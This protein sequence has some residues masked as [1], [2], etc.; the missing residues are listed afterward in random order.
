MALEELRNGREI[1]RISV[2]VP[3]NGDVEVSSLSSL[4]DHRFNNGAGADGRLL[5]AMAP[6]KP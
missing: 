3:N 2:E 1:R 6:G 4:L 5:A